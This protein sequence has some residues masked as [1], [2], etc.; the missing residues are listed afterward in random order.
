MLKW[1]INKISAISELSIIRFFSDSRNI[2]ST[3]QMLET[4]DNC[5]FVSITDA[6]IL[7]KMSQRKAPIELNKKYT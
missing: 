7:A 5:L 3:Y 4:L 6:R 1:D 2:N